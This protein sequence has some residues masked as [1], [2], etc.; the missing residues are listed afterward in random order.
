L[1]RAPQPWHFFFL[2][3]PYGASFGFVSVALPYVAKERGI[4]VGAIGAVVAAAY[5]PHAYKFLWAPVVDT[6]LTR[7]VWYLVALALV[8]IGTFVSMATPIA[9]PSLAALTTVVVATQSGLT[10][11]GMACEAMIGHGVPA[12]RKPAAAGWLQAGMFLGGGVGGGAAIELMARLGGATGGAIL[13]ALLAVCGLPLF[14][15]DEHREP[16]RSR[17]GNALRSLGR[18]LWG[19]AR[20]RAGAIALVLCLSPI[21]SGAAGNLFGALADEWHASRAVVELTTGGLAGVVSA[22]GAAGRTWLPDRMSRRVAYALAG[23]LT[24]LSGVGM[25]IAPRAA[26]AYVVFTLVYLALNG[27][28]FAAFSAFAFE[29]IGLGAVAT[30]Y[31]VLA[32]LVSVSIMYTTRVDSL[33]HARWGGTGVL[34][35]DAAM[36]GAGIVLLAAIVAV[37]RRKVR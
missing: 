28:A 19:L 3:L 25:A 26:W 15:F 32:S 5:M 21:G 11:L 10:L 2:I 23:G 27:L 12:H 24:A 6:T 20:S 17:L 4:S 13:G 14:L 9:M 34:L 31:N 16:D 8:S 1:S 7:K 35:T 30:K 18:D 29:T 33:A 37:T 22:A 36:T